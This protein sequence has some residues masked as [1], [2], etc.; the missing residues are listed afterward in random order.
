MRSRRR[1]ICTA[2]GSAAGRRVQL[3]ANQ[4]GAA[5][6]LIRAPLRRLRKDSTQNHTAAAG[7][8]N[9]SNDCLCMP[10]RNT[11]VGFAG[12]GLVPCIR[13]YGTHI[14]NGLSRLQT[15]PPLQVFLLAAPVPS[16][17]TQTTSSARAGTQNLQ[18]LNNPSKHDSRAGHHHNF[19]LLPHLMYIKATASFL[20]FS[21]FLHRQSL[22]LVISNFL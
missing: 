11:V 5:L 19:Q 6:S 16:A 15:C 1:S 2:A 20:Y 14:M 21:T 10:L 18:Y 12:K 17:S 3:E 4:F 13:L 7:I 22:Q 9:V 8:D